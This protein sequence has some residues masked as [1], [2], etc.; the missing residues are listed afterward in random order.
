MLQHRACGCRHRTPWT[1]PRTRAQAHR[2]S[3]PRPGRQSGAPPAAMQQGQGGGSCCNAHTSTWPSAAPCL[4]C[5]RSP[6]KAVTSQSASILCFNYS[7]SVNNSLNISQQLFNISQQLLSGLHI[8][9]PDGGF[10]SLPKGGTPGGSS[11]VL[12]APPS[13]PLLP[14]RTLGVLP[15]PPHPCTVLG[16]PEPRLPQAYSQPPEPSRAHPCG[17]SA[18]M[19]PGPW[20]CSKTFTEHLLCTGCKDKQIGELIPHGNTQVPAAV[21]RL[22]WSAPSWLPLSPLVLFSIPPRLC[23]AHLLI[24]SPPSALTLRRDRLCIKRR[25]S[26][27]TITQLLNLSKPQLLIC[28]MGITT[29]GAS[30]YCKDRVSQLPGRGNSFRRPSTLRTPSVR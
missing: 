10:P 3:P 11:S 6:P 19:R 17:P 14:G 16:P 21:L 20:V 25:C 9:I 28:K 4:F 18:A 8:I 2:H 22:G 1:S 5:S 7:T 26:L 23:T 30:G 24:P 12:S 29:V 15:G 13:P 27:V